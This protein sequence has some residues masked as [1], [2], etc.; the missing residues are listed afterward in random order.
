MA[1]QQVWSICGC[2]IFY[3]A[4]RGGC[5]L[6]QWKLESEETLPTSRRSEYLE[7][8]TGGEMEEE[9]LNDSL[10]YLK[11]L[12]N[13]VGRKTPQSLLI[14][15][16]DAADG[17]D[18]CRS[19]GE[20]DSSSALNDNFSD[21][22]RTLKQEMVTFQTLFSSIHSSFHCV[23]LCFKVDKT[24]LTISVVASCYVCP[25]LHVFWAMP[26]LAQ[27][28]FEQSPFCL[29]REH[30]FLPSVEKSTHSVP[31]K[32]LMTETVT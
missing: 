22:I 10:P 32:W 28:V 4:H 24:L 13:K 1:G 20:T 17:E 27:P 5:Q 3:F 7:V 23:I 29:L 21:K 14:W 16:K 15:I 31:F 18:G 2:V 12:E 9:I 8:F 26:P 30:V 19:D 11:E 6:S 25:D